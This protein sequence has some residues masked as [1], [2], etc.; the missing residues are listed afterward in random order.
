M[1]VAVGD[2]LKAPSGRAA[3]NKSWSILLGRR[4]YDV[5]WESLNAI[6][7]KIKYL[8]ADGVI[9]GVINLLLIS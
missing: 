3:A 8:A 5:K 4:S 2:C 9:F 7:S 1:E 6:D